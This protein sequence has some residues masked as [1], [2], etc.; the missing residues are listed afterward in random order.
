MRKV[1][2]IN[3][4]FYIINANETEGTKISKFRFPRELPDNYNKS[5]S[6]K[7]AALEHT[8]GDAPCVDI[9]SSI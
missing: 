5:K 3:G 8:T 4:E 2:E 9:T 6:V 7:K 1:I